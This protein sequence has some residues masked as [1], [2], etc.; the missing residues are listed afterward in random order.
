M[1]LNINMESLPHQAIQSAHQAALDVDVRPLL[2]DVFALR[3]MV[4]FGFML[5]IVTIKPEGY[6]SAYAEST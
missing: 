5:T 2:K 3:E 6:D 4:W 1:P